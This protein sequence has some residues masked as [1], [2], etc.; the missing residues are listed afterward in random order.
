MRRRKIVYAADLA[1]MGTPPFACRKASRDNALARQGAPPC[2]AVADLL[3]A[4]CLEHLP[5]GLVQRSRP[6]DSAERCLR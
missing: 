4:L 3:G 5:D 2:M 6:P 1:R